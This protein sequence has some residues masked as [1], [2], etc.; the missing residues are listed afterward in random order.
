MIDT[1][2]IGDIILKGYS[3]YIIR[4]IKRFPDC[5]RFGV[6]IAANEH[7]GVK[8]FVY[9]DNK[10]YLE[11]FEIKVTLFKKVTKEFHRDLKL[12]QIL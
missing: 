7:D 5:I 4:D 8:E 1:L 9:R 3:A 6:R 2:Q 10:Y 11:D 12:N